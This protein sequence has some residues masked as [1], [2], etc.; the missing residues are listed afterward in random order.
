M[1]RTPAR[2]LLVAA[3]A[4]GLAL[5]ASARAA[6]PPTD[7]EFKALVEQDAKVIG[8]AADAVDKAA[9]KEKRVVEK[10][11]RNGIKSSAL[12]LAELSNAR[13]GGTDKAADGHAAAV[14]DEALK[15]YKAAEEK[16]F[17]DAADL[18]KGLS[19]AKPAADAKK[20]DILKEA[21]DLTPKEVMHNFAKTTQF[22]TNAEADIIANAKKA[23]VK[24]ADAGLIAR[25]V[26][27]LGEISKTVKKGENAAEKKAWDDYNAQMIKTAEDLLAVSKK[28]ATAADLTKAFTAVNAR[29]TACHD[30]DKVGK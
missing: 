29:C 6:D 15:I 30:D 14:R 2:P 23:T 17:K 27:A 26:L 18:A 12:M 11:A 24:P 13:I 22:G 19:A 8:G 1:R 3:L 10:N 4:L 20:I 7:A 9:G 5:L 16:K 21:G 25:R 28:K